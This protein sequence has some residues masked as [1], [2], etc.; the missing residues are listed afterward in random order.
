MRYGPVP[1]AGGPARERYLLENGKASLAS[2]KRAFG[3]ATRDALVLAFEVGIALPPLRR[4]PLDGRI[5]SLT[6]RKAVVQRRKE[7]RRIRTAVVEARGSQVEEL[8]GEAAARLALSASVDALNYLEDT[9]LASAA[10]SLIHAAGELVG[11]LYGCRLEYD[12]GDWLCTCPVVVSHYRFGN[13]AGFTAR[14]ECS[15]CRGDISD[16]DECVHEPGGEYDVLAV[17][18]ERD[19]CSV[20]RQAECQHVPGRSY[21]VRAHADLADADIHEVSMVA[22]PRDPLC[23]CDAVEVS[24]DRLVRELGQRPRPDDDLACYDCIGVCDGF[25][26]P[27]EFLGTT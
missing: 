22:R 1:P 25:V 6:G 14:R 5:A 12:K 4:P 21:R 16:P 24:M 26:S 17:R 20:C 13:S 18:N 27:E 2:A 10:H 7:W 15:V 8:P 19:E 3:I 9:E 23:R 11:G